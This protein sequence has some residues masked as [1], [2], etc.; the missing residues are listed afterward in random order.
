ML[1]CHLGKHCCISRV[2]SNLNCVKTVNSSVPST[3]TVKGPGFR[4]GN[5]SL[6]EADHLSRNFWEREDSFLPGLLRGLG[7]QLELQTAP[8]FPVGQVCLNEA[9]SA[10]RWRKGAGAW[11]LFRPWIHLSLDLAHL[12]QQM[13]FLFACLLKPI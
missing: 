2:L 10:Q 3:S 5:E 7:C 6:E 9:K 8:A 1:F 11:S 13:A 4:L 12:K